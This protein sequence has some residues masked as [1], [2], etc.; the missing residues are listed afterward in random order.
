MEFLIALA[1]VVVSALS[2]E[3]WLKSITVQSQF[4]VGPL[5]GTT[6]LTTTGEADHH[7]NPTCALAV[8][9]TLTTRSTDS[10]GSMTLGSGHGIVTS[11]RVDLYWVNTDGTDG[12]CYGVIIG[13]VSGTTVPIASVEGGDV[14]PAAATTIIVAPTNAV[15]LDVVGNNLRG[16]LLST[17]SSKG[18]IVL[19]DGTDDHHASFVTPTTAYGWANGSGITNPIA[20]DTVT[21]VYFSAWNT[22]AANDDLHLGAVTA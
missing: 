8:S 18:Y 20:G 15:T 1:V 4:T 2:L 6:S 13:T 3:L 7:A 10:T 12:K 22:T 14:L 17:T 11:Q 9:G 16:L 19:H 21:T 5:T